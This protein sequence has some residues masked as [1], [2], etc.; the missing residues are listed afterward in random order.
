MRPYILFC[1]IMSTIGALGVFTEVYTVTGG[2]PAR[3][4]ETMGILMYKTAFDHL[5]FGYAAVMSIIITVPF[6]L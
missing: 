5:E 4:S 3:A 1:T 2:G 6:W